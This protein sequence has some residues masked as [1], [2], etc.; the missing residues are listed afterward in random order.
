MTLGNSI[1]MLTA[2]SEFFSSFPLP[3]STM[4]FEALPVIISLIIIEGLLSIDNALAIAAMANHLPERQK[5]LALKFGIIG[6]YLFRGLC[7]AFAAWIIENPWLKI[8]GAA[9]LIYLMCDHIHSKANEEA[10]P[11]TKGV[12]RGF[13]GT[14]AAIEIMDLSL[15]VDNV[16]AAVAMSPKLWVVCTGVFIGILALRFVAGACIK[17]IEKFPILEHT[18]FLL[19]GY[20]GFILVFEILSDPHGGM[21]ILPG[22]VHVTTWQKFIGISIIL[23]ISILYSRHPGLQNAMN[24]FLKMLKIPARLVAM[25][26]HL[27]LLPLRMISDFFTKIF[28]PKKSQD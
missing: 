9:Y 26:G 20:V 28:F 5:Y 8:G 10:H 24:P 27:I 18:A 22:P 14:I 6:A 15:S 12:E 11:M 21:Q 1:P 13:F 3:T 25:A 2:F 17:L 4:I 16:V 7:L 19:V 23:A